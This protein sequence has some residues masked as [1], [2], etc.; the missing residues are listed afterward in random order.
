MLSRQ[1]T[2]TRGEPAV[3]IEVRS[4]FYPVCQFGHWRSAPG[5]ERSF[6]KP[7]RLLQPMGPVSKRSIDIADLSGPRQPD[8]TLY[9]YHLGILDAPAPDPAIK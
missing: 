6:M 4:R 9:L 1:V 2:Y 7:M 3:P 5:P 8:E